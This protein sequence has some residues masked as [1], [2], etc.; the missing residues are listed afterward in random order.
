VA[1]KPNR[2]SLAQWEKL[3]LQELAG[4]SEKTEAKTADVPGAG[5]SPLQ[6]ELVLANVRSHSLQWVRQQ[7]DSVEQCTRELQ[8]LEAWLDQQPGAQSVRL[9]RLALE[10]G[11]FDRVYRQM[12]SM[13][14]APADEPAGHV[15]VLPKA[16]LM[17]PSTPLGTF[18]LQPSAA[19][20]EPD[21][22]G[23]DRAQVYERLGQLADYLARVEP[24]SPTPYLVRR[25]VQWGQMSLPE[26]MDEFIRE[27]GDLKRFRSFILSQP[28]ADKPGT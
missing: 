9:S 23:S 3:T 8:L 27:D 20:P 25:A 2:I 10:L 6:C 26:V 1:S 13:V 4:K 19:G 15:Q 12:L 14:D 18:D 21:T 24:H 22:D 5:D 16:D 28:R 7:L 11:T 17:A